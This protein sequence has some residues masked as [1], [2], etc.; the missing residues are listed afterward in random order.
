M[1][2]VMTDRR[3]IIYMV[4]KTSELRFTVETASVNGCLTEETERNYDIKV[5]QI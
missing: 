4:E 5:D 2:K 1:E 3:Y